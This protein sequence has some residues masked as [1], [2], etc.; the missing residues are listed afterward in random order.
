MDQPGTGRR[1]WQFNGRLLLF[2]GCLLPLLL[3]LGTWQLNRSEQKQARLD[4]WQQQVSELTW[5]DQVQQGLEDGQPVIVRGH[6]ANNRD[7][8][9][10]NRTRKG[11][12]GYEVL[13]VFY[14][15]QGP[16]LVVN[17]GWLPGTG[18]RTA[19]PAVTTPA[20][21]VGIRGRLAAFPQPPVLAE[22]TVG[23]GW[24]RRVQTL[25]ADQARAQTG[26]PTLANQVLRLA[27]PGEAGA[28]GADWPPDPMTPQ[29]HLGYAVQW[30]G[31]ALALIV[32]TVVFSY[33]KTDKEHDGNDD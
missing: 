6:Y 10:D 14:P 11:V 28:Y 33:R 30:Y 8:L 3:A 15:D 27:G 23:T 5:S 31:L 2:S 18:S 19:L 24:P 7:W 12:P 32:L 29:R 22:S 26:L 21:H 4:R 25:P 17:R 20:G 9:L 13:T 16:P 1:Q